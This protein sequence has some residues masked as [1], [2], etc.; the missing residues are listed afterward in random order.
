MEDWFPDAGT[1][2]FKGEKATTREGQVT[3]IC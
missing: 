1:T 2:Y 3:D